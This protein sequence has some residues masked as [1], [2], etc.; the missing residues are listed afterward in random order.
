MTSKPS[1]RRLF[2]STIVA[3]SWICAMAVATNAD[4]TALPLD[5]ENITTTTSST[6]TSSEYVGALDVDCTF[7]VVIADGGS[8]SEIGVRA[9]GP[10][11]EEN[12]GIPY[13]GPLAGATLTQ[14]D[15]LLQIGGISAPIAAGTVLL[16]CTGTTLV[17]RGDAFSVDYSDYSTWGISAS[18]ESHDAVAPPRLCARRTQ[19]DPLAYDMT[20]KGDPRCGDGTYDRRISGRD[21]LAALKTAV[22]TSSCIPVPSVCDTDGDGTVATTDALR[23]LRVA[24]EIPQTL[25]CPLPCHPGT[26]GEPGSDRKFYVGIDRTTET[27]HLVNFTIVADPAVGEFMGKCFNIGNPPNRAVIG[28][29]QVFGYS[30][31][32]LPARI[33]MCEFQ[34]IGEQFPD[35]SDFVI[36]VRMDDNPAPA[37]VQITRVATEY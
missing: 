30:S 8:Y 10:G 19:C 9:W 34:A 7:D 3:G 5:V 13:D 28:D 12:C 6:S 27:E 36:E 26:V 33:T 4:T 1:L 15:E 17:G 22:G 21:A 23:I 25:S 31:A 20:S 24:V 18:T 11:F 37:T 16:H 2:Q 29:G 35:A 32:G 14:T